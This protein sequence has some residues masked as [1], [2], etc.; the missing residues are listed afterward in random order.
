M[1]QNWESLGTMNRIILASRKS[2]KLKSAAQD[3]RNSQKERG[4]S[5]FA[6]SLCRLVRNR[7]LLP[8]LTEEAK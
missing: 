2:V 5:D 8:Q 3:T 4:I 6:F 1:N 7:H